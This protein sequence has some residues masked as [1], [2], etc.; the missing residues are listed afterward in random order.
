MISSDGLSR[1]Q[2]MPIWR[3]AMWA[4]TSLLERARLVLELGR[5]D[6]RDSPEGAAP[7]IVAYVEGLDTPF[8]LL[9][10]ESAPTVDQPSI[11]NAFSLRLA[12]MGASELFVMLTIKGGRFGGVQN[13]LLSVWAES[14][15]GEV[16]CWVM[17]FRHTNRG[18]QQAPP[19]PPPN[20]RETE[21]AKRLAGL[22][23]PRH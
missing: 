15:E 18:L 3:D 12:E 8:V 1:D 2:F 16:G 4:T 7:L 5:L 9:Q 22:L 11:R 19:L 13:Y 21:I 6:V 14:T 10:L 20:P 17:P 23:K